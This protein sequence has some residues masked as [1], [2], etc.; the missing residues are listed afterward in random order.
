M[1]MKDGIIINLLR[2]NLFIHFTRA[3]FF[4]AVQRVRLFTGVRSYSDPLF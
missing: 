1:Q 4:D 3:I 2:Q